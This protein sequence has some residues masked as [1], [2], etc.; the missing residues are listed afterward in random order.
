MN[1]TI[2]STIAIALA[3]GIGIG[4]GVSVY[5]STKMGTTATASSS[6]DKTKKI[7][8]YRNAMNPAVTSPV[9]AK[10]SM[11]MDYVPVYADG[12]AGNDKAGTVYVY[13]NQWYYIT[14]V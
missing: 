5:N 8:F 13:R 2:L 7:L 10:D 4:Y 6:E 12:D 14:W 11:G 3:V 1:K 9:P